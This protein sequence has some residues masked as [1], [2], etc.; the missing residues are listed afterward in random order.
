MLTAVRG[1]DA[2]LVRV[3]VMCSRRAPG[4]DDLISRSARGGSYVLAGVL[5]SSPECVEREQL[6]SADVPLVVHDIHDF[7]ARRGLPL[8]SLDARREFDEESAR[9][10]AAFDPDLVILC[11][12]LHIVTV[13][14]LEAH[15]DRVIN[16]H[17]SDLPR[18]PGLHAVRD[19][20][21]AGE[22]VTRS[23]VHLATTAVDGGLLLLRSW[24]FPTHPLIHAARRWGAAD[25]LKAF[26]YAQREWMMRECW[27]QMLA[28]AIEL[29]ANGRVAVRDGQC[30][31]DG[32]VGPLELSALVRPE[33]A[34]SDRRLAARPSAAPALS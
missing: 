18:F 12:Y 11:G 34:R 6:A 2:G 15:P 24:A 4:L 27:G 33:E 19:A 13:P 21:F 5:T 22:R 30:V 28:V 25:I 9:L 3:A 7:Y 10:L 32:R 8:R 29:F 14:L 26:A 23:T 17:D 31:V 1:G 20:V 16:I